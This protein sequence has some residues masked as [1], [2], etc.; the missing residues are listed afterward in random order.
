MDKSLT[1]LFA[2]PSRNRDFPNISHRASHSPLSSCPFQRTSTPSTTATSGTTASDSVR[3]FE[4]LCRF[5]LATGLTR[6]P[7][8]VFPRFLADYVDEG[9]QND[10]L[11]FFI[12][13]YPDFWYG[14][15]FRIA[16]RALWR[17]TR[18]DF[19]DVR[20]LWL[21]L[22]TLPNQRSSLNR[23]IPNPSFRQARLP[24]RRS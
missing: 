17:E 10:K 9:Q 12:H 8:F 16:E 14:C 20:N 19:E 15:R 6:F 22:L 13:G 7:G 21:I 1:L 3:S 24:C 11:M 2:R 23:E 18:N 5:A 4:E